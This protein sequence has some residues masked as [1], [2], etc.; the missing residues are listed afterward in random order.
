[1]TL[2]SEQTRHTGEK[3]RVPENAYRDSVFSLVKQK[4]K[5]WASLHTLSKDNS[6]T[7]LWIIKVFLIRLTV[8]ISLSCEEYPLKS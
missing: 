3:R 2:D 8:Q 5:G 1:M 7:G 6:V 4:G